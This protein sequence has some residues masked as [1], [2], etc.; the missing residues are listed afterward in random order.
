MC[1]AGCAFK[2]AAHIAGQ[3]NFS[4]S[5]FDGCLALL[6]GHAL[7]QVVRHGSGQLA[8]LV[9]HAGRFGAF[10]K[11]GY[12]TERHHDAAC[13]QHLAGGCIAQSRI[14]QIS[15]AGRS[16]ANARRTRRHVNI[17]ESL[18]VLPKARRDFHDD[19][20]LVDVAVNGGHLALAKAVVQ[21]VVYI[22]RRNAQTRCGVFVDRDHRLNT[23]FLLISVNV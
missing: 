23:V 21:R 17:F 18:R 1:G 3:A 5:L 13:A 15:Q 20:V 12:G 14:N 11:F 10:R 4:F 6:Q 8:V 7:R 19:F 22:A 2:A 9:V 16:G